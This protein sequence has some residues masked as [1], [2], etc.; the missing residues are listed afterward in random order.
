[1]R[2][3]QLELEA[4]VGVLALAAIPVFP[5]A[6]LRERL[7]RAL[8]SSEAEDVSG[9]STAGAAQIRPGV[10]LVRSELLPWS[11]HPSPGVR[12]KEVFSDPVSGSRCLLVEL[13]PG[14]VFPDHEHDAVEELFVLRGS[15]SVAGRLLLS[16]DFCRSESGTRDWDITSEQ[17]AVLLVT[18][19]ASPSRVPPDAADGL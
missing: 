7:W 18:L 19:G 5:P 15:F 9:P 13:G 16:G 4:A 1:M 2:A 12:I 14:S 17:G 8:Q 11:E 6:H 3:E 10:S